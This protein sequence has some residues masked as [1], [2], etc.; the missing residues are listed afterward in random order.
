MNGRYFAVREITETISKTKTKIFLKLKRIWK[1]VRSKFTEN[2]K[3]VEVWSQE[4]D[5][6]YEGCAQKIHGSL[7][8]NSFNCKG[9]N[10]E[11]L[12]EAQFY[13]ESL[14]DRCSGVTFD[15]V[16]YTARYGS[17]LQFLEGVR[18]W[19]KGNW[20]SNRLPPLSI[21]L[22]T[23]F[24]VGRTVQVSTTFTKSRFGCNENVYCKTVE[25][26]MEN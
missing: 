10:F 24:N 6:Y 19:S 3:L 7:I 14:N 16:F 1:I 21:D 15:G 2:G 4:Q 17:S 18:S 23:L 8:V 13:C 11:S 5:G 12:F 22:P 20:C 26:G 9:E 25:Y